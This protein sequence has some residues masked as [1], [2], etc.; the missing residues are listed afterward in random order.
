MQ[1]DSAEATPD[2]ICFLQDAYGSGNAEAAKILIPM[3]VLL[4]A[5][6]TVSSLVNPCT[7]QMDPRRRNMEPSER[8]YDEWTIFTHPK[9]GYALPIPPRVRALGVPE[10]Q[11]EVTFVSRDNAFA[12]TAWGGLTDEAP[13]FVFEQEW[14]RAVKRVGRTI[15]YQKKSGSWFVV[16]GTDA[17]GIEFY[18][19]FTM[20]G[21][22][23]ASFELT[24]PKARLREFDPLVIGIERGFR[25]V[26][27]P[28]EKRYSKA[29]TSRTP[30]PTRDD[31]EDLLS[32]PAPSQTSRR[33]EPRA[34]NAPET[35]S[36]PRTTPPPR[37]QS[38]AKKEPI[39]PKPK[40]DPKPNAS[41]PIGV[42]AAGKPGFVHSPFSGD[43]RLVDVT[44]IPAGTKVKCPYTMKIF[45]VP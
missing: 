13:D 34:S 10:T 45:L 35:L 19:K 26:D 32:R 1:Y 21:N 2:A 25:L 22:H 7:A 36:K 8:I 14:Q 30:V 44:G 43:K 16:S 42:K 31:H 9:S 3:K 41:L 33:E 15:N 40:P 39:P 38:T 6:F 20:L 12:I 18:Q 17:R 11:S 27:V 4:T 29:P 23:I 5:L 37:T 24:Y 28:D